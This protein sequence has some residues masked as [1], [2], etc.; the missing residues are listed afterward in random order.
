LAK[1]GA[2]SRFLYRGERAKS[3]SV[4]NRRCASWRSSPGELLVPEVG[5]RRR[6]PPE[7]VLRQREAEELA[8]DLRCLVR[9]VEH[10]QVERGQHEVLPRRLAHGEVREEHVVVRDD[11]V[12][13]LRRRLRALGVAVVP[14]RAAVAL[15]LLGADRELR[16][17]LSVR[18]ERQLGDVTRLRRLGP[19]EH[20]VDLPLLVV[21]VEPTQLAARL[22]LGHAVEADVVV[23]ALEQ[24]ERERPRQHAREHRQVLPDELLL[25]RDVRGR[26]HDA[27][28]L[29]VRVVNGRHRVRD[30]L[31]GS[32][33]PFAEG[34]T[35][36]AHG[37][38]DH[39]GER[40]LA[41]AHLVA[42]EPRGEEPAVPEDLGEVVIHRWLLAARSGEGIDLGLG[43]GG[44]GALR[45]ELL[46]E[47]ARLLHLRRRQVLDALDA[48]LREEL[49]RRLAR[50][51]L[52]RGD[53]PLRDVGGHGAVALR[54]ALLV[55]AVERLATLRAAL[56]ASPE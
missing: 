21:E 5:R 47:R 37:L 54:V 23:A 7:G 42:G 18:D 17:D 19:R 34:V 1:P 4:A 38:V 33:R 12:R 56:S 30:R 39:A 52:E 46:D 43:G 3:A 41:L 25:Q 51:R 16:P 49:V 15:A 31:A 8:G 14:E 13:A 40:H 48:E 26:D 55:V 32:A 27:L 24:R 22:A 6:E 53:E 29:V 36:A 44:R 9:L 20:L 35:P 50:Q 10:E 2:L 11:D 45:L 28:L